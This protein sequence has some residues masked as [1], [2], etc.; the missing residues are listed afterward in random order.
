MFVV[1]RNIDSGTHLTPTPNSVLMAPDE[2]RAG[3]HYL[4]RLLTLLP[5][6]DYSCVIGCAR[7][8]LEHWVCE[9]DTVPWRRSMKAPPVFKVPDNGRSAPIDLRGY[10]TLD[11]PNLN[12]M[13]SRDGEFLD[14]IWK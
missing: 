7:H 10:I 4:M 12:V 3:S 2:I 5:P 9:N 11:Y 6:G 8:S 14:I 13:S 1:N